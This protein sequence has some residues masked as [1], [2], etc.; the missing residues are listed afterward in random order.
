MASYEW[1]N[2]MTMVPNGMSISTNHVIECDD[3]AFLF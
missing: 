3:V 2:F 1:L